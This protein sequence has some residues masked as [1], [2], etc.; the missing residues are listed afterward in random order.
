MLNVD[1]KIE[2]SEKQGLIEGRTGKIIINEKDVGYIGE[3]HPET[4]RDWNIKIPV[5]VL[6]NL[7]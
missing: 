7:T 4:L 6:E 3:L 5:A 1:Y 2:P